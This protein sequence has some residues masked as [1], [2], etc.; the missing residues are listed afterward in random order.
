MQNREIELEAAE[1]LVRLDDVERTASAKEQQDWIAWL[2]R[3]PQHVQAYFDVANLSQSVDEVPPEG[4]RRIQELLAVHRSDS[5]PLETGLRSRLWLAAAGVMACAIGAALWLAATKPG[6]EAGVGQQAAYR[7]PDGSFMVLNTRSHARVLMNER[8]RVVDLEGEAMFTVAREPGRP[9]L[10][11]TRS[12]VTR[13]VGTRFNVYYQPDGA[14]RVSVVEGA[15]QVSAASPSPQPT[16]NTLLLSAGQEAEIRSS[17]IA[18][19]ADSNVATSV[20]WQKKVLVFEDA[21]LREV[22]AQFNRYNL[23]QFSI[24]PEVDEKH[25]LSGTFDPLYPEY[26]RAYLEKDDSLSVAAEG[27]MVRVTP[28]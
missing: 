10:V 1:W 8:E 25:R 26:F 2:Q 11:R 4:R 15:V 27:E 13:A 23:T 21:P 3:S 7:L 14:T 19:R 28:R 22:A 9:F 12:A 16:A 24:A 6:Y 18:K 5:A 20:A 17:K